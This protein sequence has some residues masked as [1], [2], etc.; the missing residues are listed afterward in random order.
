M[1]KKKTIKPEQLSNLRQPTE[2]EKQQIKICIEK[3]LSRAL[4]FGNKVIFIFIVLGLIF[5]RSIVDGRPDWPMSLIVCL[6]MLVLAWIYWRSEKALFLQLQLV[7]QGNYQVAEGKV[8]KI[9]VYEVPGQVLVSFENAN[10]EKIGFYNVIDMYVEV[11]TPLKLILIDLSKE[12]GKSCYMFTPYM[13]STGNM[14]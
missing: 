11:G 2:E 9:G 1:R 3:Y 7:E 14:R 4:R 8:M 13:L 6:M 12:K 10:G 5:L